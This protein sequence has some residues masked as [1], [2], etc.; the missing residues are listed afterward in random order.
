MKIND[1]CHHAG[2]C[3]IVTGS[4]G[5]QF[6]VKLFRTH[7]SAMRYARTIDKASADIFPPFRPVVEARTYRDM[8]GRL[9]IE[10]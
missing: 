6:P 1:R 5:P 8:L 3:Y 9:P 7:K 10:D 2:D 4:I